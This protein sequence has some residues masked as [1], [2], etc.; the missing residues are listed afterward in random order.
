MFAIFLNGRQTVCNIGKPVS[1]SEMLSEGKGEEQTTRKIYRLIRVH[2]NRQTI[3]ALGPELYNREFVIN[4]VIRSKPVM[5]AIDDLMEKKG[6]SKDKAEQM[7]IKCVDEIASD[8]S[9]KAIFLFE[10]VLK[11]LWQKVYKGVELRNQHYLEQIKNGESIIY[12]P[13]HKSHMDYLLICYVLYFNGMMSPH[14]AAG[15]NLNFWP[16]GGFLRK[17][18]AFFLRRSFG[19][20]RLYAA[21]FSE[22][23]YFLIKKGFPINFFPEGGRSRTGRLLKPKTGMLSMVMQAQARANDKN[24]NLVPVYISYDKIAEGK[25][26]ERERRGQRKSGESVGQLV[27]ARKIL[28]SKMGRAYVSFGKPLKLRD[29]LDETI[30]GWEQDV[31]IYERPKWVSA[32]VNRLATN[33]MSRTNASV[34]ISPISVISLTMLSAPNRALTKDNFN[35]MREIFYDWLKN[36]KYDETT[37]IEN[38]ESESSLELATELVGV[39]ILTHPLGDI[40]HVSEK[41]TMRLSYYSNTIIHLFVLPAFISYLFTKKHK[42]DLSSLIDAFTVFYPFFRREFFLKWEESELEDIVRGV[43]LFMVSH[44]MLDPSGEECYEAPGMAEMNYTYL[45]TTSGILDQLTQYYASALL[46]LIEGNKYG[47]IDRENYDEQLRYLVDRMSLLSGD[48][49]ALRTISDFRVEFTLQIRELNYTNL[50]E[51]D[52]LVISDE[53]K[54]LEPLLLTMLD[55]GVRASIKKVAQLLRPSIEAVD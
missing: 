12:M 3:A 42:R 34:I 20:D 7:A 44:G 11:W 45:Q 8:L 14:T 30:P 6:Y 49:L 46:L 18:G 17:G 39:E 47:E 53:L 10:K 41:N 51:N 29:Y 24:I 40:I 28:K 55:K 52:T 31:S 23:L 9:Y 2:F 26:Y 13:T 43:V 38:Y 50:L 32:N 33:M 5:L 25:T 35:G 22:Y 4:R 16:V 21:C 36:N 48:S 1:V 37:V 54:S 27:R 19:G 15:I